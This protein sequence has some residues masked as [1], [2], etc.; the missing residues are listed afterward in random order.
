ME[1]RRPVAPPG[2]RVLGLLDENWIATVIGEAIGL[3][4]LAEKIIG[5]VM[6]EAI[7]LYL[8]AENLVV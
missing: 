4:L 1:G 8:L 2:G 7:G 6:G 3:Y 5:S